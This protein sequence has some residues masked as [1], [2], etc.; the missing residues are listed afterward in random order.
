MSELD[1]VKGNCVAVNG[2][3]LTPAGVLKALNALGGKHGIGR[4]DLVENRFRRHEIA[5]RV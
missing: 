1:F 4:V 2:R 5:R 3:K